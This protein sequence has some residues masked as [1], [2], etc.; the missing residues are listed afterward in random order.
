MH[1]VRKTFAAIVV[2]SC[3]L[4]LLAA[5]ATAASTDVHIVGGAPNPAEVTVDDGDTVTFFNDDDVEHRIFAAGQ[6]RGD[7]IAPGT[8]TVFGPFDTGGQRGTFAYNVDENG[9]AGTIFVRGPAASTSTTSTT[10]TTKPT[11]TTATTTTTK[12]ATTT[13]TATTVATTTSVAS[14]TTTLLVVQSDSHKKDSSNSLAVLGFAL[15]VAGIGGLI[16]AMGDRAGG[17]SR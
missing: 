11:T 16:V 3:L 4:T 17:R 12:P 1:L 14:T 15:L 2:A 5:P 6:Q 13:T 10:A 7:P 9:P 8:S